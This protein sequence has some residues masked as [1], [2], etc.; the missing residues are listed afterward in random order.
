MLD[1]ILGSISVV[2][3]R[4]RWRWRAALALGSVAL[5]GGCVI[6]SG[7][8]TATE[9]YRLIDAHCESASACQCAWAV[10]SD[11][12]CTPALEARWKAR[13]SEAQRRDLE[14]DA[15]CF[16]R[17]T[18][19]IEAQG[20]SWPISSDGEEP[21]LCE[22]HCAPF[23]GERAAGESCEGDD[24]LVSD[25]AQGLLCAEGECA[26]PCTTLGGRKR[27]E[28]CSS[29]D[30]GPFDDCAAGLFCSWATGK[31]EVEPS[32]G[33]PCLDGSCG[34]SLYCD[35]ERNICVGAAEAGE[36]CFDV[37]CVEGHYCN[38]QTN[39]CVAQAD[40]GESCSQQDCRSDLY[41]DYTTE[42]CAP[43]AAEG[44]TCANR[45]CQD[46]L[47]CG[48]TGVCV[49]APEVGDPCLY[50]S[51]CS[52]DSACDFTTN[53]CTALPTEGQPCVFGSCAPDTW[54]STSAMDPTGICTGLLANDER[55]SG[56][57]QCQ[58]AYCPNGFCWARPSEGES[59]LGTNLCAE[60][61]VC[62]GLTCEAT[63][64]RAPATCSY[65]G[66]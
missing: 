53:V 62:N 40:E 41:C 30:F 39:T 54:C 16:A 38:W 29:E 46:E 66:W 15:E 11:D 32:E 57:R 36:S 56:H 20:C 2:R 65:P 59:C 7:G 55:C 24:P 49:A 9:L 26:A 37:P 64:T 12:A 14:Y 47:W 48:D 60:G 21:P 42:T 18:N 33:Q 19:R 63:I 8:P 17:L 3:W 10:E 52:E 44:Q 6:E 31:C 25:C 34:E 23:H 35:W 13:L 4:L 45:P 61:L 43:Y 58:S 27:G 50:G 28:V 1:S 22:I 51:L 5:P